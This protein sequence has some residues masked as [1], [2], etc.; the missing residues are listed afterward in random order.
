MLKYFPE[1]LLRRALIVI[2]LGGLVL[3]LLAWRIGRGELAN[4]IWAAGTAPVVVGLLISI[5]RDL[6]AG[7]MG[8]DAGADTTTIPV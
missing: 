1:R 2:G 6:L 7:R 8:V 4:W 3:G 5:I